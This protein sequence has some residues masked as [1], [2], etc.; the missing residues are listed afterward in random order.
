MLGEVHVE[1]HALALQLLEEV[2]DQA[3]LRVLQHGLGDVALHALGERVQAGVLLQARHHVGL[4]AGDG[5]GDAR[6]Q[7]LDAFEAHLLLGPLVVDLGNDLL[8][9]DLDLDLEVDLL[10]LAGQRGQHDG[11]IGRHVQRERSGLALLQAHQL[12]VELGREQVRA[13][14]VGTVLGRERR[15]LLALVVGGLHGQVDIAVFLHLRGGGSVLERVV[16]LAQGVDLLVDLGIGRAF[17]GQLDLDGLVA[18]DL[19]LGLHRDGEREGVGLAGLDEVRLVEFRLGDGVQVAIVDGERIG[20]VDHVVGDRRAHGFGAQGVVDDRARGLALAE[21]GEVVLVGEVLVGLLDAGIDVRG[22]DGNGHFRAV[23]F[24][25]LNFCFHVTILHHSYV[26]LRHRSVRLPWPSLAAMRYDLQ[27][28]P[29]TPRRNY[30]TYAPSRE[31]KMRQVHEEPT[32]PGRNQ[33][34]TETKPGNRPL[35]IPPA[36][37]VM[38]P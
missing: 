5:L 32:K 21:P 6:T 30:R 37:K 15:N 9:D 27:S 7:V 23:I 24:Q 1:G 31:V 13:Q 8:L 26:A 35:K 19:D 34:A 2:L 25:C 12:L 22:I 11:R 14:A 33:G 29:S 20:A 10:G 4:L 28:K 38:L 36:S 3:G 17:G 18:G 16:V